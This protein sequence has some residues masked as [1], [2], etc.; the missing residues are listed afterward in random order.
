MSKSP[1]E[2]TATVRVKMPDLRESGFRRLLAWCHQPKR[3]TV[4]TIMQEAEN[5]SLHQFLVEHYPMNCRSPA[6]QEKLR[7]C[8]DLVEEGY[9]QAEFEEDF[10][11]APAFLKEGARITIPGRDYLE[12]IRQGKPWRRF[13][14]WMLP[15]AAGWLMPYLLKWIGLK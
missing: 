4:E 15:F 7:L 6:W 5:G 10:D 13:V 9:L 11:K 1:R 8:K 14:S 3:V 2:K 12:R